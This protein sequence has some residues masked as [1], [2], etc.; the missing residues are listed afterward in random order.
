[1]FWL[2]LGLG[3]AAVMARCTPA[4]NYADRV[5]PRYAGEYVGP[6]HVHAIKLVTFNVRHAR[7]I[8]GAIRVLSSGPLAQAD[9]IALQEMDASGAQRIAKA[10]GC[11]YVY[12]PAAVHPNGGKDFGNAVLARGRIEADYK[13]I[14]PHH[15]MFRKMQRIAVAA[16]VDVG[17]VRVRVYSAHLS[18]MLELSRPKRRDQAAALLRDARTATGPVVIAGDFN[19]RDL[20]KD[21]FEAG[22]FRSVTDGLG[23]TVSV[24]AWDHLYVRGL[25]LAGPSRRGIVQNG[26]ASDHLPVWAELL[27]P[28]PPPL[29]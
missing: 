28:A 5:G 15:S 3:L 11:A 24:F 7:D 27:P 8:D 19:S 10:L 9:V 25:E 20:V 14:L 12:Y 26:G 2:A 6:Q 23:S 16:S 22:G 4:L 17:G 1:M 29:R 21:V 13:L 18:T